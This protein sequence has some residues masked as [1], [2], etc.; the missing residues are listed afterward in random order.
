MYKDLDFKDMY[1]VYSLKQYIIRHSE[2]FT[3]FMHNY[4]K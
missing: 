1:A 4:V 3:I 2:P